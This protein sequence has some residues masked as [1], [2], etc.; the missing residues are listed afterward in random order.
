[1]YFAWVS[2]ETVIISLYE[3]RSDRRGGAVRGT[4]TEGYR[5]VPACPS[6]KS[7]LEVKVK[8]KQSHYRVAGG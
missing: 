2:E 5:T 1:M 3:R 8:V 7:R 6:D 4:R